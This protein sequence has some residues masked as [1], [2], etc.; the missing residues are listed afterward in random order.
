M[1]CYEHVDARCV[2]V[3]QYGSPATDGLRMAN[4]IFSLPVTTKALSRS[5]SPDHVTREHGCSHLMPLLPSA[6]VGM[7]SLA[8]PACS[9]HNK[10]L[11]VV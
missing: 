4:P 11:S 10:I 1:L 2:C 7:V 9:K 8:M 5:K 6:A 3:S